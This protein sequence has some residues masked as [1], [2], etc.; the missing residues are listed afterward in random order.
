[1]A[2]PGA[3]LSGAVL[4]EHV[5][6]WV[7]DLERTCEFYASYF[8]AAVGERYVNTRKGFASRF[9]TFGAG[10]RI[11]VMTRTDVIERAGS[12]EQLGYAHVALDVGDERAVD[13]LAARLQAEG[14]ALL[15]APR[16]TGDGY[17]ECVVAD[18]EGNR[19]EV[20]AA[21]R[22]ATATGRS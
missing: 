21:T 18:P 7:R 10:T 3:A 11:E 19:V 22:E 2:E 12:H 16:R 15:S 5:G 4:V 20:M 8:A 17:Y 1:M 13:A 6:L 9:L 14:H